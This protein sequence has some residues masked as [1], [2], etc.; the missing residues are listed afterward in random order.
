MVNK[1][2]NLLQVWT[3]L[4]LLLIVIMYGWLL[5]HETSH[6]TICVMEGFDV[7]IAQIF[8]NVAVN[9]EGIVQ[10]G[11]LMMSNWQYFILAMAPYILT[12]ILS[13]LLF[14]FRTHL[15][16][17]IS[18]IA[19]I[20]FLTDTAYNFFTTTI[21]HTD[22]YNLAIVNKTLFTIATLIVIIIITLNT[23]TIK[24]KIQEIKQEK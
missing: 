19:A 7:K 3:K 10:D 5:I 12:M 18:L 21:Y 22:F 1:K 9:C 17:K 8:P 4:T 16:P 15:P 11:Q 20:T 23:L 2:K 13:I 14:A 24:Q 6:A